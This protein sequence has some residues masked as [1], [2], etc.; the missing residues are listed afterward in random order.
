[1]LLLWI[2]PG[3]STN[4]CPSSRDRTQ[5]KEFNFHVYDA[6]LPSDSSKID[7][8]FHK[9]GDFERKLGVLIDAASKGD[10]RAVRLW[11]VVAYVCAWL[12]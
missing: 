8:S 2:T 12:T 3:V 11:C 9:G 6:A 4:D 7:P 5:S 1:M 10:Y